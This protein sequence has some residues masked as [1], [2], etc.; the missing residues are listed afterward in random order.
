M[1]IATGSGTC[2]G[3]GVF[4]IMVAHIHT[5]DVCVCV[6]MCMCVCVFVCVHACV[7]VCQG[8]LHTTVEHYVCTLS[9]CTLCMQTVS[10]TL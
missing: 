6:C 8:I 3:V 2:G 5:I 9:Y 10:E 1:L 4:Y 7:C